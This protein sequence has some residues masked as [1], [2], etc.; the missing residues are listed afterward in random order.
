MLPIYPVNV[1]YEFSYHHNDNQVSNTN[2]SSDI[3]PNDVIFNKSQEYLIETAQPQDSASLSAMLDMDVWSVT[4][5]WQLTDNLQV[6]G[7]VLNLTDEYPGEWGENGFPLTELGF[8]YGWTS[9]PFSLAGREYYVRAS[10]N[11]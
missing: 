5:Q 8:K 11:F 1:V 9:F 7:G 10:Y 6:S 3:V 2:T 4:A